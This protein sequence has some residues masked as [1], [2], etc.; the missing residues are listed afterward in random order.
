M[1]KISKYL[2]LLLFVLMM[3]I[4]P[5]SARAGGGGGGSGGSGGGGH[6]HHSGSSSNTYNPIASAIA[7]SMMLG[8]FYMLKYSKIR[9]MNKK[10]KSNLKIAYDKDDFWSEKE[11]KGKVKEVYFIIQKAWSKQDLDTLKLYLTDCLYQQWAIKIEWQKYRHEQNVLT[12]IRLLS[13]DLILLYDDED[14]S[15]DYF[16]VAIEGYMHDSTVVDNEVI[17]VNNET[18]IEYWKF[19]R[20]SNSILLDD[21]LQESQ[22]DEIT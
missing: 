16:W 21:I 5:V 1:K 19:V 13:K 7:I 22:I 3:I 17:N 10:T 6:S 9:E 20:N 14:N 15:K 8:V 18:F 12:H 11:L 4:A 2:L